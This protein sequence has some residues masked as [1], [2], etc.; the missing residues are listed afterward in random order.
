MVH[1]VHVLATGEDLDSARDWLRLF[2]IRMAFKNLEMYN[3][4]ITQFPH[5]QIPLKPC[6][7]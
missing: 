2:S 4:S 5:P 6:W 7:F 3:L 1:K